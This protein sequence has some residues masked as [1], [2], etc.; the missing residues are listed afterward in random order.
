MFVF[1]PFPKEKGWGTHIHW[2]PH[3][4]ASNFP[5]ET[6]LG[7][8]P[9]TFLCSR[10]ERHAILLT[11]KFGPAASLRNR[12]S[13]ESVIAQ[14]AECADARRGAVRCQGLP[15]I[16]QTRPNVGHPPHRRHITRYY[17][18]NNADLESG[19][20]RTAPRECPCVS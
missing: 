13:A 5:H 15:H 19:S 20:Q 11:N 9:P 4:T 6:T 2:L 17:P 1:P 7:H 3:R 14:F 12:V 16:C 10:T 8:P 18:F